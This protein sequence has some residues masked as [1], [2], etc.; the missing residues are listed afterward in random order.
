MS[1]QSALHHNFW[2]GPFDIF[3][4]T[5]NEYMVMCV[6]T[7]KELNAPSF[8]LVRWSVVVVVVY[9]NLFPMFPFM[10]SKSNRVYWKDCSFSVILR[11]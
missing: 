5:V 8:F 10:G 4:I 9:N 3:A 2:V 1:L 11:K 6:C 7:G